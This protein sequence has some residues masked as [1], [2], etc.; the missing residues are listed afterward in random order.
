MIHFLASPKG[1]HRPKR[2]FQALWLIGRQ[3]GDCGYP[4]NGEASSKAYRVGY[5]RYATTPYSKL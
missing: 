3:V 2:L 1:L 5:L 4:P